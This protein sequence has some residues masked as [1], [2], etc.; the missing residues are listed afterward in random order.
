MDFSKHIQPFLGFDIL[1]NQIF[2]ILRFYLPLK[3][4]KPKPKN[5]S[6]GP[7]ATCLVSEF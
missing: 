5:N 6:F 7:A 4:Q 3:K 1:I 2:F